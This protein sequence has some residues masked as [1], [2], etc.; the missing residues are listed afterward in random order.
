MSTPRKFTALGKTQTVTEWSREIGIPANVLFGRLEAGW[1][2]DKIVTQKN[3]GIGGLSRKHPAEYRI[4]KEMRRRCKPSKRPETRNYADRGILVCERW[5]NSFEN[6]LADMGPRPS[7]DH[8][9]DRRN[10]NGNYEKD[11]C[12]WATEIE[13]QRNK[14]TNR[15][16]T[17]EGR[18]MCATAWAEEVGIDHR[19]IRNRVRV[20]GWTDSEALTI[21]VGSV[22]RSTCTTFLDHNGETRSLTDWA[23]LFGIHPS[24]LRIRIFKC[25]WS[26]DESLT[27]P[28]RAKKTL[29]E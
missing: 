6:F 14:R 18:T 11:N 10:N 29:R 1:K 25:G 7:T 13:Q 17:H 21:P 4:W 9:I 5:L 28:V 24:V 3:R 22:R 26:V 20:Q 19:T 16:L 12:Y 2:G 27:M 23:D 15:M 8:S